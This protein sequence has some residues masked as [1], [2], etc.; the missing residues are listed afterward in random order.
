MKTYDYQHLRIA[1]LKNILRKR[2]LRVT[3]IKCDLICR[4]VQHN[5]VKLEEHLV[6]DD[7]VHPMV[8]DEV[9]TVDVEV[10]DFN[11]N[12]TN[13]LID[14]ATGDLYN[15]SDHEYIGNYNIGTRVLTN[16]QRTLA[17]AVEPETVV[18]PEPETVVSPEPA[19][20]PE[21]VVSPNSNEIKVTCK[22]H[23]AIP[24]NIVTFHDTIRNGK[25]YKMDNQIIKIHDKNT[26]AYIG[27]FKLSTTKPITIF[28]RK[29]CAWISNK[30]NNISCDGKK[31]IIDA[32]KIIIHNSETDDFID[33]LIINPECLRRIKTTA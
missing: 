2:G 5:I 10:V 18:S 15:P 33:E 8:T 25:I 4:L 17:S 1:D 29:S 31:Y 6:Q 7:A 14:Q 27:K 24:G 32:P 22:G 28:P 23:K 26:K 30:G 3:G 13:Y 11:L 21:T 9:A 12:G 16:P 19:V 20:E